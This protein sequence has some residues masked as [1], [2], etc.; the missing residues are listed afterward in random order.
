MTEKQ[1]RF[2]TMINSLIGLFEEMKIKNLEIEDDFEREKFIEEM[3]EEV[4]TWEIN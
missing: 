1:K 4:S 2:D 3:E